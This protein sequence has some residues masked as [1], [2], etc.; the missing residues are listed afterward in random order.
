MAKP[1]EAVP[2][3]VVLDGYPVNP[4][5]NPW[6]ELA[7]L[8]ELEVFER[9]PPSSVF[10]RARHADILI[11]NKL[12]LGATQFDALPRLRMVSVLAT[13]YDIID[14]HAARQRG[15]VV[16]NVPEYGSAAVAEHTFALIFALA[17]HVERHHASVR[18]GDWVRREDFSYWC[19]PQHELAGR[20]LGLIGV[21]RIGARVARIANALDMQV[22]AYDT[23]PDNRVQGVEWS[24]L[25]A[26]LVRANIVSLH[27][28]LTAQNQGLLDQHRFA[29]MK[30][31]A[32]L[33]N[34]ARAGLIEENALL[35]ALNQGQLG[36]AA[37]DVQSCEP[38]PSEHPFL[39][40]PKL[41]LTPHLAWSTH[42]ARQRLLAATVENVRA[43]LQGAPINV[44]S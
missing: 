28:P 10:E 42:A 23:N 32:W 8:G 35:E 43:F 21:G 3:I 31:G 33:I 24:S 39:Q 20:C 6:D 18:S 38:L 41:L 26:L 9:S 7:S 36:A 15:I 37:L 1:S 25:E 17:R 27:C 16:C 13:G 14:L 44:V 22:L 29:L 2:R 40:T 30:P 11:V 5:D 12:R 34:T 19:T 4:G